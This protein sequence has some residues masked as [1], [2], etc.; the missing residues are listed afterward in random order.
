MTAERRLVDSYFARTDA[1][2]TLTG[3]VI[4]L[5]KGWLVAVHES[6]KLN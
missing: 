6:D 1:G 2:V 4:L 3:L 5:V